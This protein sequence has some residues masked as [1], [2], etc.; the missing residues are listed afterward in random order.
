MSYGTAA[1]AAAESALGLASSLATVPTSV[2]IRCCDCLDPEGPGLELRRE[3]PKPEGPNHC[4]K[5][6]KCHI[7]SCQ[8]DNE[9]ISKGACTCMCAYM[10]A[11]LW[12][13][14]YS[15]NFYT[16]H[17]GMC[18]SLS[19]PVQPLN[20]SNMHMCI[21]YICMCAH[22]CMCMHDTACVCVCVYIHLRLYLIRLKKSQSRFQQ[23]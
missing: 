11:S 12:G 4:S 2:E 14:M 17:M 23:I 6:K 21:V 3:K 9:H 22:A 5:K 8:D 18:L 7:Q 19:A 16:M 10:C 15:C 13:H 1:A 20:S